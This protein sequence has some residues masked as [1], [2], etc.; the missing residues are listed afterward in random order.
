MVGV[1]VAF[2]RVVYGRMIYMSLPLRSDATGLCHV[3][4]RSDQCLLC[5]LTVNVYQTN[6]IE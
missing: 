3:L 1:F 6:T 2:I 5:L 4:R